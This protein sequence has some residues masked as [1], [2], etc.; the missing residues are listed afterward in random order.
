MRSIASSLALS[1]ATAGAATAAAAAGATGPT[2]TPATIVV[3]GRRTARAC[4]LSNRN[5]RA[6]NTIEVRLCF[7]VQLFALIILDIVA[8]LVSTSIVPEELDAVVAGL[9]AR[10]DVEHATWESAAKG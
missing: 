5:R 7:F 10:A 3:V 1:A 2:P 6:I 8:T 4:C 9:E